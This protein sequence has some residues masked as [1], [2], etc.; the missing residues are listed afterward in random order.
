MD[1]YASGKLM[2]FGE[3]LVLKGSACLAIPLKY[4]QKMQVEKKEENHIN[5]ISSINGKVWF[6]GHFS[7]CLDVIETTDIEKAEL[8]VNVLKYIKS[9]KPDLFYTGLDFKIEAGFPLEWGFGASSTLISCLAQWSG[10]DP[11]LLLKK[12]FGGSGYDVACAVANTP[13]LYDME[14]KQTVPVYLFPKITSKLLFV[15]SGKK[16]SS[17]KEIKKFNTLKISTG[18]VEKMTAIILSAVKSTQIEAFENSVI[19][20]E[21]LL[22]QIL[23]LPA[24]KESKFKDYPYTV[25]SLGAWGGD[26]FMATYRNEKDARN[27]FSE[28]G[29]SIQFN[30]NELIKK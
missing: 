27:Y 13:I 1:Y 17:R 10:I 19:E 25:K 15:Y 9:E 8:L 26:F 22:S 4:G 7:N 30:Y 11:F 23:E 24:I 14:T 28:L 20:S 6:S 12:S 5:W 16:Q 3:Y 18:Q 21:S 29:Y 2:L